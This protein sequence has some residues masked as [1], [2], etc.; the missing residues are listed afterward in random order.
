M[1]MVLSDRAFATL[2]DTIQKVSG[3]RLGDA[4]R[5]MVIGRL[6]RLAGERGARSGTIHFCLLR[7][8]ARV[9]ARQRRDGHGSAA[10]HCG[11]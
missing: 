5:Q 2:T 1:E 3:I 11:R 7:G 6:Q 4:K 9:R 8:F 10:I